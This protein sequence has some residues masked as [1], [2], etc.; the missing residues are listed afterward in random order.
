MCLIVGILHIW[1]YAPEGVWIAEELGSDGTDVLD[2]LAQRESSAS[3]ISLEEVQ[4]Q[5]LTENLL[6]PGV[7]R[8]PRPLSPRP[9]SPRPASPKSPRSPRPASPMR[10]QEN[11]H[12]AIP[13]A[14]PNNDSYHE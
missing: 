13:V 11:E 12:L 5:T 6:V 7:P 2:E 4:S 1:A 8:S 10:K 14:P 3:G 9:R